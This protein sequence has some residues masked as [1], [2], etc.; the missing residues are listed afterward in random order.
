MGWSA[1]IAPVHPVTGVQGG[2]LTAALIIL[3][4]TLV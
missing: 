3:V 1:V 4:G 2:A